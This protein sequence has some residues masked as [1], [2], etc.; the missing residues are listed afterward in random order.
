MAGAACWDGGGRR[1]E[2]ITG[3]AK[4]RAAGVLGRCFVDR[5]SRIFLN[6]NER[7]LGKM[8]L[9]M[10]ERDGV[11]YGRGPWGTQ[12][13]GE[14]LACSMCVCVWGC[15]LLCRR[16]WSRRNAPGQRRAGGEMRSLDLLLLFLRHKG[17]GCQLAAGRERENRRWRTENMKGLWGGGALCS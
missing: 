16:D 4:G 17:Q 9:E 7:D 6:A 5:E 13:P 12:G 10:W 11:P 3:E 2:L 14:R 15:F 1:Q 8:R